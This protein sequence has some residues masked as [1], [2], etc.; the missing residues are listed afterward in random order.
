MTKTAAAAGLTEAIRMYEAQKG[1]LP[2]NLN[3]LVP[4]FISK[5]PA[6]PAGMK[7]D[8]NPPMARSRWCRNRTPVAQWTPVLARPLPCVGLFSFAA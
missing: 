8:Y 2:K 7:Y 1:R 3:E 6:P 4:E 5:L